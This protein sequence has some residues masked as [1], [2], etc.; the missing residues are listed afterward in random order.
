[1]VLSPFSVD[2][3]GSGNDLSLLSLC[4]LATTR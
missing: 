2:G 1:M 4:R 3:E